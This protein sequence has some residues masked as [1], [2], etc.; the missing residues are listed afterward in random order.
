M[1]QPSDICNR[2]YALAR[3]RNGQDVM[4]DIN[5]VPMLVLQRHESADHVL[6]THAAHYRKDMAWFRQ[7]LGASRFCEEGEA[8]RIRRRITHEHFTHFDREHTCALAG[9]HGAHA[10]QRLLADSAKGAQTIDDHVLRTMTVSILVENFLGIPFQDTGI[11]LAL[12]SELMEYGS[13][14]SFVP[15][16]RTEAYYAQGLRRLP[17]LRREILQQMRVLRD[18]SLPTSPMLADML[19]ADVDPANDIVLEHELVTFLAAGAESSAST[20]GWACYLLA[21]YPEVQE[22]LRDQVMQLNPADGWNALTQC[23]PLEDFISEALRLFPPSPII[24]RQATQADRIG[25]H[26]VDSGQ[27]LLISFIGIG[28]D[29]HMRDDP[30]TLAGTPVVRGPTAGN[31]MAFSI[32]PRI[33]GGK[34][35]ALVELMG[36]L[37]A[38]LRHARFELTCDSPPR[39]HWKAQLLRE[40]GHPVRVTP[41]H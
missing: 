25:I 41:L 33:C 12:I 21:R 15:P 37:A 1:N 19:R 22:R 39:F 10:V 6:R 16:G 26:H 36:A 9:Q 2:L 17:G 28:H 27:N 30:W 8:W 31:R 23:T 14:Y 11:D 13:A 35:F 24:S 4:L 18:G 20:A 38:F 29:A 7:A 40:G 34:L 3:E 32:G 5:G